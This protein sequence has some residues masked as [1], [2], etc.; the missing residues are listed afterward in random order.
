MEIECNTLQIALVIEV[1]C[2][3]LQIALRFRFLLLIDTF[4]TI[5]IS[6]H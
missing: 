3:M 4:T 2:N 1:E 5:K 6:I